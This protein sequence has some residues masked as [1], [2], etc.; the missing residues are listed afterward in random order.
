MQLVRALTISN[1][2]IIRKLLLLLPGYDVL[3]WSILGFSC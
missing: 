1:N 3:T 2:E